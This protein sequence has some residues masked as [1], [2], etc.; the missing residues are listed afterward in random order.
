[1]RVDL[2]RRDRRVTHVLLHRTEILVDGGGEG[3]VG[4]AE[5][6]E[7]QRVV[8]RSRRREIGRIPRELEAAGRPVVSK[9]LA[10]VLHEH[11]D[12]VRP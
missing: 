4:V 11:A 8:T 10:R 7:G 6:V 5:I 12:I 1:M 9:R 2:G 3:A